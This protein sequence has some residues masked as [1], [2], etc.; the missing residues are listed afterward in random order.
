MWKVELLWC[1]L[2]KKLH[3]LT[4]KLKLKTLQIIPFFCTHDVE[5]LWKF[6][7][8]SSSKRP[9]MHRTSG[10]R[11]ESG[12]RTEERLPSGSERSSEVAAAAAAARKGRKLFPPSFS[13]VERRL[14]RKPLLLPHFPTCVIKEPPETHFFIIDFVCGFFSGSGI[15]R[16]QCDSIRR[17]EATTTTDSFKWDRLLRS[18]KKRKEEVT[19]KLPFFSVRVSGLF[20]NLFWR[21]FCLFP[22]IILKP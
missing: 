3:S 4:E 10:K 16:L 19:W 22:P 1:W 12:N 2:K 21:S 8:S 15:P 6:S 5:A 7:F 18:S 11:E 9:P 20:F 13:V 17:I 14:R